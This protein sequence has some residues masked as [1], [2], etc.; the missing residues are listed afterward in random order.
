MGVPSK[1]PIH[2]CQQYW[3]N[4]E[5]ISQVANRQPLEVNV[6]TIV[7]V[8]TKGRTWVTEEGKVKCKGEKFDYEG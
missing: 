7:L 5:Y 2:H 1:V 8:E 4:K 6:T 3:L